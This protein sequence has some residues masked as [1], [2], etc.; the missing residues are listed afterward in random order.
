MIPNHTEAWEA[1]LDDLD[2]ERHAQA[3][4]RLHRDAAAIAA[5]APGCDRPGNLHAH[6]FYS[7]NCYG[8]SPASYALRARRYGMEVAGIVDF[9]VLDGLEEFHAAG[10]CL[11]LRTVVSLETRV[12]VPELADQVINSPGEPGVAYHMAAGFHRMPADA[13]SVAFL[14]GLRE[15]AGQR[16]REVLQKVNA[17]LAPVQLDYTREVQVLTPGG[18]ATERH[19]VLAY[20]RKAAQQIGADRLLDYWTGKLGPGL[21]AKDL[22]ESPTLLNLIRAK[23]MKQGGAGYVKP[24]ADTFPHLHAFNDFALAA[25]A[26]PM[27]AW[28]D[29][30]SAGE[31]DMAKWARIAAS[32]GATALN[33]IPDRNFTPG[34]PDQKLRNLLDVVALASSLHWPV[35]AGTEMNSPGQRFV[36]QFD[37]HELQ[38]LVPVFQHGARILYAHTALQRAGGLGY[39]SAWAAQKL[40]RREDRNAFYEELGR[41]LTPAA[42]DRLAGL[43]AAAE[44][45]GIL[46]TV[47]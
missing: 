36:D 20:A 11:G 37:T 47:G 18:N 25:G 17:C 19:M 27:V 22:P 3:L 32:S 39:L 23:T 5:R 26:L 30:T 33:I 44:P 24:T 35:I 1:G 38:P 28:L 13:A 29:G 41:R 8:W 4:A 16:N 21:Q 2:Q 14:R 7:F 10:R 15:R 9:D 6:T 34:K 31:Q 45:D 12:F 46:R 42:E 40:A 43:D